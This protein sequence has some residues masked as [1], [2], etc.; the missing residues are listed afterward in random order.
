MR[1]RIECTP[2]SP[3]RSVVLQWTYLIFQKLTLTLTTTDRSRSSVCDRLEMW[4]WNARYKILHFIFSKIY[5]F[6]VSFV[7]INSFITCQFVSWISNLCCHRGRSFGP[8]CDSLRVE[9]N[10]EKWIKRISNAIIILLSLFRKRGRT[11]GGNNNLMAGNRDSTTAPKLL[12]RWAILSL[13]HVSQ[14]G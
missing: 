8:S 3:H 10:F 9:A 11:D 6:L 13:V 4:I 12:Q 14:L 7:V 1:L 2:H 5:S